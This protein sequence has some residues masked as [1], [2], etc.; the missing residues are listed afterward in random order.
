[1]GLA[2]EHELHQRRRRRNALLGATLL[3]FV[4][5]VFAITM[6]KLKDGRSALDAL[7]HHFKPSGASEVQ[8]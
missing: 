6:V 1:M 7:D 2:H 5:L 8:E 4:L 3:G